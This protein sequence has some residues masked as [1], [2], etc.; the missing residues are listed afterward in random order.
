MD[1][2]VGALDVGPYYLTLRSK[3]IEDVGH[4]KGRDV[5]QYDYPS[6][7]SNPTPWSNILDIGVELVIQFTNCGVS[8][9]TN[10]DLGVRPP[11][12]K[13]FFVRVKRNLSK[14]R[15]DQIT[16]LKRNCICGS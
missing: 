5:V 10:L 8:T 1:V 15:E 6:L 2:A 9:Q 16:S 7:A 13:P 14:S 12:H 4:Q 11:R 3:Q